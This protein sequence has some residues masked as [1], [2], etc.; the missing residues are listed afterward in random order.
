[1]PYFFLTCCRCSETIQL[2]T[3]PKTDRGSSHCPYFALYLGSD[4]WPEVPYLYTPLFSILGSEVLTRLLSLFISNFWYSKKM[5]EWQKFWLSGWSHYSGGRYQIWKKLVMKQ[6]KPTASR[7]RRERTGLI[8]KKLK[9]VVNLT[10]QRLSCSQEKL[11][12]KW[13]NPGC[14]QVTFLL[15][16]PFL[17]WENI[18]SFFLGQQQLSQNKQCLYEVIEATKLGK[19]AEDNFLTVGHFLPT[20]L[21]LLLSSL[22]HS[23]PF[24]C[25]L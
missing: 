15:E 14:S 20:F 8:W 3:K 24:I 6:V 5:Y 25:P 16:Q 22:K 23:M 17:P 18:H 21:F 13:Y 10:A 4:F 7:Y 9:P 12:W 2:Q 11:S 1:M 19:C